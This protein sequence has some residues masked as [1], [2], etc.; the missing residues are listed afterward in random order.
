[1]YDT[2]EIAPVLP[3][4]NNGRKENQPHPSEFPTQSNK[5]I[6]V[7]LLWDWSHF[8]SLAPS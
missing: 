8:V 5:D 1:M 6:S 7:P 2:E 4:S 3:L